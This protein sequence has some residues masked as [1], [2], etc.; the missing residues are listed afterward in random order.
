MR[1]PAI[2]VAAAC[3]CGGPAAAADL[4]VLAAGDLRL[5]LEVATDRVAAE[6][7]PRFDRTAVVRSVR[8][9]GVELLGPWGLPDEFGLYGDG[10]LGFESAAVDDTFTKIGIG[11]LRRDTGADYRFDQP[12]P[13]ATLFPVEVTASERTLTVSQR[14]DGEG[15]WQYHYRKTY[16]LDGAGAL[17][18]RYELSNTGAVGWS[19]EHYNHHW[20]RLADAP[21][22][23]GYRVVTGF[24][25]PAAETAFDRARS[26]LGLAEPLATGAAAYYASE[27]AGVPAGS[28]TFAWEVEGAPVVSYRASFP[29]ARF[30]LYA[31]GRGFC[32]EVFKRAALEPGETVTWSATYRFTG[33]QP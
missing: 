18:I 22:G 2:A 1:K 10:V 28:N 24:A 33:P 7:G 21:V 31:D 6:F 19:F 23:P 13:V 15:P 11:R 27:L 26:A 30:A 32:P 29:P 9:D 8:L 14:S 5:E 4:H 20:F 3:L 25:L 17:T 12:Y 16:Q